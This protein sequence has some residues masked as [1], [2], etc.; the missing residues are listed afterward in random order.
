MWN[1][2][3]YPAYCARSDSGFVF[4]FH[5]APFSLFRLEHPI[6]INDDIKTVAENYNSEDQKNDKA[7]KDRE[8]KKDKEAKGFAILH[9]RRPAATIGGRVSQRRSKK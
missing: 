1:S 5:F 4:C 7:K 3:C 8:A 2:C 6:Y 9:S